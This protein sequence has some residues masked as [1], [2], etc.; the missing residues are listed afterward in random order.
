MEHPI[1]QLSQGHLT[2][3]NTCPR[4][5]QHRYLDQLRLV[6]L[7][8]QQ[9][10]QQLGTQFHHLMQQ[11]ALGLDIQHL[12]TAHP[13][14]QQWFTAYQQAPPP[15]IAGQPLSEHQRLLWWQTFALVVVY[16]RLILGPTQAQ[17]LDWKTYQQPRQFQT[18]SQN[19]QT[20]LYLF[21]LAE[22]TAY[23]PAHL[24]MTYWFAEAGHDDPA[25]ASSVTVPYTA[26]LHEHTRQDLTT[27]LD[28][29][30]HGL[31]QKDQGQPFPQVPLAAGHCV[32]DHPHQHH[33]PF[34][35]H[36]HRQPPPA[37][38]MAAIQAIPEVPF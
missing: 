35:D 7:N 13:K 10:S 22:T 38:P 26:A 21:V 32:S 30:H 33:C 18:L 34:L 1:W 3:L 36:C 6:P 25:T 11:H 20:R 8:E 15:M 17:I 24:S 23:E 16:D 14:L 19:W 5:F 2:D 4:K 27:L 28:Q 12:V 31:I 37:S 29:L 9:A